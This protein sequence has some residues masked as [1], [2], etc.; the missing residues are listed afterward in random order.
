MGEPVVDT[1]LV[2]ALSLLLTVG[3]ALARLAKALHLPSVTG[4]ILAGIALGPSWLN[5]ISTDVL[6]SRLQVFTHIALLL[7]AFG[8]GERFD[9]QQLRA[10][11]RALVRVS[12]GETLGTFVLVG[13]GVGLVAWGTG[14]G[15]VS[16][17][18]A[19]GLVCASIAVATAPAATVMVIRELEATGPVSR[20]VLSD[21]VVNNAL[22]VTL[23]G[24][25]VAAAQVLL[26]TGGGSALA[27][28]T[29]PFVI[30]VGSLLLGIAV[31]LVCD[32]VVHRL[33]QRAD[34]LVVALAAIFFCGGLAEFLGLSSLLAGV[35]AGFAV[36][37]RDR[38][39][40]RAFRAVNDFEPPIY[41]IFFTLAGAQLHLDELVASGLLGAIFV[42]ARAVGKYFGAWLGARLVPM[43]P[44]RARSIGLGLLPQAGL[45]IGLAYLVRQ[46]PSLE[47]IRTLVINLVVA[48]VVVNELLGPPLVRMMLMRAGEVGT[49]AA[50]AEA[51]PE[52]EPSELDSLDVV[53]WTWPKLEPHGSARGSVLVGVSHPTTTAGLTRIGVLLA[54][55][56]A[57]QPTAVHVAIAEHPDDFWDSLR[58]QEAVGLFRIADG[59]AQSLGYPLDTEVEFA[60]DA[61]L[62]MLRAAEET[63]AQAIVVGHPLVRTAPRFGRIVDALARDALCPVVVVKFAGPLHT[64]R[65]LVPLS[66]PEDYLT[67]RPVVA[68]LGA[69]EEHQITFL[70]LMPAECRLTEL[71]DAEL[72]VQDYAHCDAMPGHCRCRAVAADSRV[73]EVLEAARYHDIIV[74]ASSNQRGLRRAFFGSLA[75]DVA[76]RS[77]RSMLLVA[78]GLES[79]SI[80]EMGSAVRDV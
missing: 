61:A 22:S 15:D 63:D 73:H 76:L 58:D 50:E 47:P 10:Q 57:A 53:P 62:G 35:A 41:G 69:V 80:E 30:T 13:A 56:Y 8:I 39:D 48:S 20:L 67:L 26:G 16:F 12:L 60:G 75:E 7:V 6:E 19:V 11:A 23:F 38:R 59:E 5:L 24:I 44:R 49:P 4:Y 18:I 74:M 71:Q 1:N 34:V 77:P 40:V 52:V 65:I 43:E 9:L 14:R 28:A 3:F 51:R 33:R 79:R 29:R 31:G 78:G 64:E 46:D 25:A 2:F 17:A 54:H 27:N 72:E 32:F 42:L 70:R 36:V 55:H 66:G 68:A 45:A 21:V 37:N